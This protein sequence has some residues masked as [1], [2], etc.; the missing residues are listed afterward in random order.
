MTLEPP[1]MTVADYEARAR[2]TLARSL[3][4]QT[5]GYGSD[6][7]PSNTINLEAFRRIHF[8]P[9]ILAGVGRRSLTTRVLGKWLSFPVMLAPAGRHQRFHPEGELASV[10]AAGAM[11]TVMSLATASDYSIDEVAAAA[12]GP[13]FF[14]L[15]LLKDRELCEM[16][17]HRAERAGYSA[18]ILTVDVVGIRSTERASRWSSYLPNSSRVFKNFEGIDR[19]ELPTLGNFDDVV[20]RDLRWSDVDW[21][22]SVTSMPIVLKGILTAEDARL[23]VK[24]GAKGIV[25]SNHGGHGLKGARA[26]VEALPEIVDAVGSELEVFLDGGI[27][28][29]TDVLKALALGARAVFIGRAMFWGLAESGEA[30]VRHVLEILRDELDVA[31]ALVG[32]TDVKDLHRSVLVHRTPRL[33]QKT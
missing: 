22:Q 30:G 10:R 17:I 2:V 13:L 20:E 25:V 16:V 24:H 5:F 4:E 23:A 31:M 8:R 11:E 14:Q 19:P 27:R 26:T 28:H 18:L 1:L 6:D 9:R 12:S 3:F 29:G 21:L 15:Y 32:V 33:A 7:L